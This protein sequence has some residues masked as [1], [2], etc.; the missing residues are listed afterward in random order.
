MV[1]EFPFDVAEHR[2]AS[3]AVMRM[4]PARWLGPAAALVILWLGVWP[5]VRRWG[6]YP[7]SKLVASALPWVLVAAALAFMTPLTIWQSS[8]KLVRVD[9]SVRG[10][11]RRAVDAAG[12]H[13]TGNGVAVDLQ[14]HAMAR[15]A[16]TEEF[17][18]FFYTK[19]L[20]YYVGKVH[21]SSDE[22]SAVRALIDS[23]A[24]NSPHG[25]G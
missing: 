18:L 24:G 20:A 8:R 9:P 16:E 3:A 5:I 19:Q 11:Q 7:A 22:C 1:V 25:P 21:L 17:F 13:S 6:D 12:F 14:W 15:C 4:L 2:R 23:H 10:T